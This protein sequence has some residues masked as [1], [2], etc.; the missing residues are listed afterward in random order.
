M[1]SLVSSKKQLRKTLKLQRSRLSEKQRRDCASKVKQ[2]LETFIGS[3]GFDLILAY[4]SFGSELS[5]NQLID[6]ISNQHTCGLPRIDS[7]S[8]ANGKENDKDKPLSLMQFHRYKA[9][10]HLFK[11]SYGIEEPDASKPILLPEEGK[12]TLIILPSLG[13]SMDGRRL[14]YGGGFYDRYISSHKKAICLGINYSFLTD[15][16]IPTE[17]HDAC[18]DYICSESSLTR[19]LKN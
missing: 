18:M 1:T 2:H 9:G 6:D 8:G 7:A 4:R 17:S 15:L 12:K 14:G 16:D 5:V 10:D 13:L 3:E 11:N 19:A